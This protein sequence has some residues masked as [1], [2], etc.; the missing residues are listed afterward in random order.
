MKRL[1]MI[2]AAAGGLAVAMPA[3]TTPASA[4]VV[5]RVVTHHVGP[6]G[7]GCRTVRTV[8]NGFAGR[9]VIVRKVCG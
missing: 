2:L 6:F 7:H 9:R 1:T 3:M 8:R 5:R 4:Y